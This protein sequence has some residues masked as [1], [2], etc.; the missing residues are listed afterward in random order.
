MCV[1][2]EDARAKKVG[3]V[4]IAETMRVH[5]ISNRVYLLVPGI[6][7]D[8]VDASSPIKRNLLREGDP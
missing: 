7:V 8:R 3:S 5:S 2:V 6:F 1:S 4:A